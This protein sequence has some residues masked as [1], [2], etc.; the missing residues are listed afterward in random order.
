MKLLILLLFVNTLLI[1]TITAAKCD[2]TKLNPSDFSMS[3]KKTGY[4]DQFVK[5]M[6]KYRVSL[7]KVIDD[8]NHNMEKPHNWDNKWTKPKQ[9][10]QWAETD[11]FDDMNTDEWIPQGISS[12]AD[13]F[14]KGDWNGKH[15]LVVSW[16]NKDDSM[17][18]VTFINQDTKKYRH[19][20]LVYPNAA[21]DFTTFSKLHAGGIV[22]YG[23][24]LWVADTKNGARIFDLS[25]IIKVSAGKK[26]GKVKGKNKWTAANYRYV[27]PQ[28]GYYKSS[29]AFKHSFL[30]LDRID[31]PDTIM[32]GEYRTQ[33]D[34]NNGAISRLVKYELDWDKR[35]IKGSK[36]KWAYCMGTE[37]MQGAVSYG[38]KY[39]IS[40]SNNGKPSNLYTWSPGQSTTKHENYFPPF[41][42]DLS[43]DTKKGYLYTITEDAGMRY[44]LTYDP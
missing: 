28:K 6:K 21:D 19:A 44:V 10:L 25:N 36:A 12:T 29:K 43:F 11:K 15:A 18:R 9:A 16:H 3:Y 31:K 40:S 2:A 38:D 20:L 17:V 37:R 42:E 13:A 14:D 41:S 39:Y 35:A 8:G 30:S 22:W 24:T 26:V 7:T 5:K 4:H 33:T 32:F 23:D 34:I 27:I 1:G